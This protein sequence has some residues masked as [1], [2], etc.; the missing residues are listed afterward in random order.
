[1][2]EQLHEYRSYLVSAEQKSQDD[3]DKTVLSLSGGA[4]GISFAFVKDIVGP[5]PLL[6]QELLL[7]S[8][9][10]WAISIACILFS[11]YF[12]NWSLRKAINQLDKNQ[13]HNRQPGGPFSQLTAVLNALG[14]LLFLAGAVLM[15]IFVS[16]N[17]R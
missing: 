7:W 2:D 12:S 14:G 4:L 13:I 1:M 10:S 11:F 3:Y 15:V 16:F 8:W 5:Q 9:S 6:R 17:L